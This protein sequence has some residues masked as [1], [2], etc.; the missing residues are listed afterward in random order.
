[1]LLFLQSVFLP[2]KFGFLFSLI[3]FKTGEIIGSFSCSAFNKVLL[4]FK[5]S[6]SGSKFK[7]FSK[8]FS[9]TDE[10]DSQFSDD[11]CRNLLHW[12]A[13]LQWGNGVNNR[14]PD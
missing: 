14:S 12:C 11:K 5:V 8:F 3:K 1:M 13:F 6:F 10:T 2:L 4:I 7:R 9:V